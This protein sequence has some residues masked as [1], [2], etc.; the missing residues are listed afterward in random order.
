MRI[1]VPVSRLSWPL[2]VARAR[3]GGPPR[4]ARVLAMSVP[5]ASMF[6]VLVG[7]LMLCGWLLAVPNP[8]ANKDGLPSPVDAW[9]LIAAG[10]AL[11]LLHAETARGWR[12]AVGW[13]L[14]A[15]IFLLGSE[16]LV[17]HAAGSG[18]GLLLTGLSLGMLHVRT[19]QGW[20]PAR[21]LA[22]LTAT[23][24]TWSL[25]G[26]LYQEHRFGL[27]PLHTAEGPGTLLGLPLALALLPLSVGILSVHPER[28][29]M[30]ALLR[31]DLGGHSARR[32]LLAALL[33]V[34]ATGAVRL[35]GE[36]LGLYGTA[37][38]TSLFVLVT[39]AAFLAVSFWNAN[40][41]SRLDA[42]RR[43]AEDVLR[44]SEERFRTSF[45]GAP[46]GM[47][48]VDLQGRFLHVN[49]A[50][51]ELVGYSREELISRS[52]QDL[53]VPEDLSV[54]QENA[55]RMRRGEIDSFQREKHYIRKDGRCIAVIV[56]GTVVRDPR[57]RPIHFISQMQDI[58]EREELEQASRFLADVGPRL[59]A[60]LASQ[61][62]LATVATLAVPALADG[63]V[64]ASLDRNGRLQQ[65]ESAAQEPGTAARL[66][67]LTTA[68]GPNPFP[69]AGI[70]AF[71]LR[72]GESVLLPE[73]PPEVLETAALD[74]G[75]LEQLRLLGLRSV[76][77]VPLRSRER[78][79]GALILAT[80]GSGRR[81]G[82]RELAQAEEL[83]RRAALAL[84]NARLF[85]RSE[86]ASRM[87]DE[88]LRIVAHDLRAPLNVI[89]L[90]AGM[91]E[92]ALPSGDGT[93][94]HLD[95]L[96]KSVHRA[97][98]LIQDL[99]DVARMEGGVLSVER[100][101]LAVAPLIQETVEQHRALAEAKSLRLVAHVPE[102]LPCVLAD[103]ERVPQI[104]ANLLGNAFKFTP[105]GGCITLRVQPE[106]GQV[107][108]LVSDTGPGIPAEDLPHI[109][110]RFWQAG[111]K[112]KEGA[113]LGLT[114]VKGLVMAHGGQVGVETTH[115]RGSTFSFTL[116]AAWPAGAQTCA[117]V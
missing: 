54:D 92:R 13:S 69:P 41:L 42:S 68:Y 5:V 79:L 29:L 72:T 75:H 102:D 115:G 61:T 104:L 11:W 70:V 1:P 4:L 19:R 51:C 14:A 37:A 98:R 64:A 30:H 90:S 63:C 105:E 59:A 109:F 21:W 32:L 81:Y 110:E 7:A 49:A 40:T 35:L 22:L 73:V 94:R 47:A 31:D 65:V 44:L 34:P 100:E 77:V 25:I 108:F 2:D 114:I 10:G 116:P 66:K 103:R 53:T 62:T 101:P 83:A 28:G 89:Q 39:M 12:R 117:H 85:E 48:L 6:A 26:G 97:N 57:G 99:L 67:A 113:G 18:V 38:G 16:V 9:G 17:R 60:S 71:V 3:P 106:A 24:A 8:V 27:A 93:R 43:R 91:L 58:T 87:R 76:I 112:R 88:V 86:Q 46:T 74:A 111:P 52:F 23:L 82:P 45:D 95:T 84:D 50:L 80:Y 96:Q 107:R 33:V 56:W 55:A 20:H 15:V 36:R 78:N